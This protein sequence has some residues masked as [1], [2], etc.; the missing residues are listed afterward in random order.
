MA[1]N[2]KRMIPAGR[3]PD[4]ML[5][6]RSSLESRARDPGRYTIFSSAWY[7][8]PSKHV[9]DITMYIVRIESITC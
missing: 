3:K 2:G 6:L 5:L 1:D 4:S 7:R 8:W 9:H